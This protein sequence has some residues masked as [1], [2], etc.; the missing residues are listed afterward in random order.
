MTYIYFFA[1]IKFNFSEIHRI[2]CTIPGIVTFICNILC[3]MT[4]PRRD[5]LNFKWGTEPL[6]KVFLGFKSKQ[7][8]C[9]SAAHQH[10]N[11]LTIQTPAEIYLAY[12]NAKR[13]I[14]WM[15]GN[16]IWT[17]LASLLWRERLERL[18]RWRWART[19][20]KRNRRTEGR[21]R[22]INQSFFCCLAL[23]IVER[24]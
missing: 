7:K 24:R 4:S 17:R 5:R 23:R 22:K 15:H 9:P 18:G 16:L 1:C 12:F 19:N 20:W 2:C 6:P 13:R 14:W 3:S 8:E 21:K 11:G 10:D